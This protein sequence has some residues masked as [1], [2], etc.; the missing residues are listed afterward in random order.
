MN[1]LD[2]RQYMQTAAYATAAGILGSCM[3]AARRR[4][5]AWRSPAQYP[6]YPGGDLGWSDT[7]C[8][9]ADLHETPNIDRLARQSLQFTNAYAAAPS[10]RP[11]ARSIMTGKH[12]ARLHIT[13][14]SE[15]A[16]S[17]PRNKKLIPP[18]TLPDLPREETTLPEALSED[19]F[20]AHIGKWH[21]AR[22]RAIPKRTD[23]TSISAARTG[24]AGDVLLPLQ[25]PSHSELRYVPDLESGD[26]DPNAYLTDRLTTSAAG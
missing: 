1:P 12:P 6:L 20:K 15:S 22:H 3:P 7:A 4:Q 9:G 14:W 10:V 11:R 19:Y 26:E 16:Q 18:V 17:P 8:Y 25:R 13:V 21:L 23:S 5:C 2:R 24:A